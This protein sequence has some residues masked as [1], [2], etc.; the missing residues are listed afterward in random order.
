M[1]SESQKGNH[2]TLRIPI[3]VRKNIDA[4]KYP[5]AGRKKVKDPKNDKLLRSVIKPTTI[6]AITTIKQA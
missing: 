5:K 4:A 6:K 2:I 1:K 3:P